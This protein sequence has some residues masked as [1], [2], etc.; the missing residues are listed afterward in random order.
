MTAVLIVAHST[1]AGAD[2][3]PHTLLSAIMSRCHIVINSLLLSCRGLFILGHQP[4]LLPPHIHHEAEH[5]ADEGVCRD[6]NCD[7]SGHGITGSF[8][9]STAFICSAPGVV[10]ICRCVGV[11]GG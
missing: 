7:Q 9:C 10:W 3:S 2:S 11:R 6:D 5:E 8:S 1:S 4:V